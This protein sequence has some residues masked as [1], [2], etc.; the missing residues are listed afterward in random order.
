MDERV[1]PDQEPGPRNPR[2]GDEVCNSLI[3]RRKTDE[4]CSFRLRIP[5]LKA[6]DTPPE[7]PQELRKFALK[8][9]NDLLTDGDLLHA[10]LVW[11]DL[12]QAPE[13]NQERS[14]EEARKGAK[15]DSAAWTVPE[16]DLVECILAWPHYLRWTEE[17]G[18]S[19]CHNLFR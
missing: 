3:L 17:T 6:L 5:Y 9:P 14:M 1:F 8:F 18:G 13:L 12:L 16:A 19:E 10:H 2:W 7:I 4:I 15:R 11:Y